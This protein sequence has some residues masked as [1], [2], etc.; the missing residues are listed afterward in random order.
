MKNLKDLAFSLL[1]KVLTMDVKASVMFIGYV[2]VV[3]QHFSAFTLIP[4]E[5]ESAQASE[6]AFQFFSVCPVA[7]QT[8][9][10]SLWRSSCKVLRP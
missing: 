10:C 9:T 3:L 5:R 6:Q 1:P 4:R 7:Q 8:P 2:M